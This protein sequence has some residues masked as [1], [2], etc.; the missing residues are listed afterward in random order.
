[1]ILEDGTCDVSIPAVS[2]GTD[3][4]LFDKY[5]KAPLLLGWHE[6]RQLLFDHLPDGIVHFDTQV[7][8]C[9]S[10]A[11]LVSLWSYISS[12]CARAHPPLLAPYATC[13][14]DTSCLLGLIHTLSDALSNTRVKLHTS[15]C[16]QNDSALHYGK[17]SVV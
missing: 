10:S 14:F 7:T 17:L 3:Q 8:A 12:C 6:I 1:M 9:L 11:P 5:G 15:Q 2:S 4:E 16:C 13:R